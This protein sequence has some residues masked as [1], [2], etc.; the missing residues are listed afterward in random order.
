MI[1]ESTTAWVLFAFL[2]IDRGIYEKQ[3]QDTITWNSI[4]LKK[5]SLKIR[6]MP[7]CGF[8]P[9]TPKTLFR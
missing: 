4:P 3:N 7:F 1:C 8:R 9:G 2:S 5:V 6:L